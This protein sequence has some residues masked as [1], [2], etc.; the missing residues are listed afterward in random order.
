MK[1]LR[2]VDRLESAPTLGRKCRKDIQCEKCQSSELS[3]DSLK[4]FPSGVKHSH[5]L[6]SYFKIL[7][8]GPTDAI[9][10]NVG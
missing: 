2:R 10:V 6:Y 4:N 7:R 9:I 1:Y 3:K 8:L 5:V